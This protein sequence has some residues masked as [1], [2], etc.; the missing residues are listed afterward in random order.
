MIHINTVVWSL[1]VNPQPSLNSRQKN[2]SDSSPLCVP[3]ASR[4][5][6]LNLASNWTIWS[7]TGGTTTAECRCRVHKGWLI[8]NSNLFFFF[9]GILF[10]SDCKYF[11]ICCCSCRSNQEFH[12]WYTQKEADL[13]PFAIALAPCPIWSIYLPLSGQDFIVKYGWA[14]TH[15]YSQLSFASLILDAWRD[16]QGVQ[17]QV[18]QIILVDCCYHSSSDPRSEQIDRWNSCG[19][20]C[21]IPI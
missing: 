18:V 6:P 17:H 20:W 3:A 21:Q 9:Q 7:K 15:V 16:C 12:F 5:E 4:P 14:C 1:L 10:C 11:L 19:S 2:L 8:H 13:F